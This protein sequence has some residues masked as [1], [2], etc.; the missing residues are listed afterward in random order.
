MNWVEILTIM[1]AIFIANVGVI[2]PLF[3]WARSETRADLRELS[4]D[5]KRI[6]E[7]SA[8]EFKEFRMMWAKESK[9]FYGKWAEETKDFHARLC[10]IEQHRSK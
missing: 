3:L 8:R 1:C 9:E 5:L 2:I 4:A 6:E 7:E 10:V